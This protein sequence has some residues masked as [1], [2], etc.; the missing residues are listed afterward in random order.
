MGALLDTALMESHLKINHHVSNLCIVKCGDQDSPVKLMFAASRASDYHNGNTCL[1]S[2]AQDA[3]PST[4]IACSCNDAGTLLAVAKQHG[5]KKPNRPCKGKRNRY[6]K[7]V[8]RLQIQFLEDPSSFE[9]ETVSLLPS[10]HRNDT[11]RARLMQRM[12]NF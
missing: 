2:E 9:L 3:K 6:K 12:D 8:K 7:L 1:L 11:Q 10:V 4:S 5:V